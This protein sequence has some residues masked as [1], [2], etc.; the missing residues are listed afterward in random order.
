MVCAEQAAQRGDDDAATRCRERAWEIWFK[1]SPL[2][3]IMPGYGLPPHQQPADVYDGDGHGGR[4]GWSWYTGAAARML[5]AAHTL[6]G[7]RFKDGELQCEPAIGGSSAPRLRRVTYRDRVL[8]FDAVP[9][10]SV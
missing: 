2:S 6:L 1:I 8:E 10:N 9:Q 4:G 5:S 7:L 3:K